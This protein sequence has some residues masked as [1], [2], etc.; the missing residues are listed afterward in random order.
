MLLNHRPH[1]LL[2][3]DGIWR[4]SVHLFLNRRPAELLKDN[5]ILMQQ[6]LFPGN[7]EF[8]GVLGG[9]W[10]PESHIPLAVDHMKISNTTVL[11]GKRALFPPKFAYR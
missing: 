2:K 7:P 11:G 5:G 1:E 10:G 9:V 3:D 6:M 8:Q 4:A